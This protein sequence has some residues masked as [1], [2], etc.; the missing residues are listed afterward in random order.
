MNGGDAGGT[1]WPSRIASRCGGVAS[2]T[3]VEKGGMW[4]D[5][6][7][8]R[9][10]GE[11]RVKA[12]A[13][14]TAKPPTPHTHILL[15]KFRPG[16]C[17]FPP[18]STRERTTFAAA[19]RHLGC[20]DSTV[21]PS[22]DDGAAQPAA[23]GIHKT[24]LLRFLGSLRSGAQSPATP[25]TLSSHSTRPSPQSAAHSRADINSMVMMVRVRLQEWT[26]QQRSRWWCWLVNGASQRSPPRLWRP[27]RRWSRT[28]LSSWTW[29]SSWLR[30]TWW[31]VPHHVPSVRF[32]SQSSRLSPP[33]ELVSTG[34]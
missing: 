3:G 17:R 24:E 13:S 5:A 16:W 32:T 34:R 20:V 23:S 25:C 21:S 26:S 1:H 15:L 7:S 18:L 8:R 12:S 33:Y 14:M 27:P 6:G 2:E 19:W 10:C 28:T 29:T 31:C 4:V 9:L 22:A 11:A 30:A